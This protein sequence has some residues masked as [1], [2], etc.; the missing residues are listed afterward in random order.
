M[1]DPKIPPRTWA[2]TYKPPLAQ[3]VWPVRQVA[4]VTAGFRCPPDTLAVMY[5]T[6]TGKVS[7]HTE[8]EHAGAQTMGYAVSMGSAVVP[9]R[10]QLSR[11][12][13]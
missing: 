9:A 3:E 1:S 8:C 11:I 4:K 7:Q 10:M 13:V 6:A 5:T 12:Q 2:R